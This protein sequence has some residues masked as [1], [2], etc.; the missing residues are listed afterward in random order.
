M[1]VLKYMER[2]REKVAAKHMGETYL[3]GG[4]GEAVELPRRSAY[5]ILSEID[6][7]RGLNVKERFYACGKATV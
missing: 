3:F 4:D 2:Q 1:T 6:A 5:D 7:M